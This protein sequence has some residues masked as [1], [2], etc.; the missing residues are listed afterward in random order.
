MRIQDFAKGARLWR[1]KVAKAAKQ[2]HTSELFVVR[3]YRGLKQALK[4]F[5]FIMFKYIH[6]IL[7]SRDSFS[8]ISYI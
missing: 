1:L 8:F 6:S 7:L 5:G 4:T 3:F 2:S